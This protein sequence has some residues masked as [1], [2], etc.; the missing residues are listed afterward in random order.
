MTESTHTD[1]AQDR[2]R[3]I[4]ALLA[5]AEATEYRAEAEAFMS[6]VSE[7]IARW[8][9]DEALVWARAEPGER[10]APVDATIVVDAPYAAR[11][12]VLV[13]AVATASGCRAVRLNTRG[14]TQSISIIGFENDVRRT[15]LLVTSL[16]VQMTSDMVRETPPARTASATASFRRSFIIGFT[17]RIADRLSDARRRAA[18]SAPPPDAPPTSSSTALVL[19]DR[20]RAV[21]EAVTSRFGRLRTSYVSAGSSSAGQ[22][23]GRAAGDRADLGAERLGGT[24]AELGS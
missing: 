12:A 3:R 16:L 15:E 7:L 8:G 21:D 4:R 1:T 11:K 24:R 18:D 9:V 19:A 22:A 10:D 5:K 13:H 14:T 23:A 2:L 20:D 17:H 6:K